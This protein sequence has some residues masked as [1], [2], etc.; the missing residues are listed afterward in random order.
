VNVD[1]AGNVTRAGDGAALYFNSSTGDLTENNTAGSNLAAISDIAAFMDAGTAAAGDMTIRDGSVNYVS[2]TT[3]NEIDVQNDTLTM[4]ELEA[5]MEARGDANLV[6]YDVDVDGGTG[7]GATYSFI[8]AGLSDGGSTL[9]V[10]GFDAEKI[11]TTATATVYQGDDGSFTDGAA[12]L[13]YATENGTLTFDEVSGATA[14]EDPLA[15]LDAALANV[16]SLRSELGAVQNRFMD[17]IT[18]LSTNTT[19]L[20]AA[21]SRIEDADY[22]VEVANMTRAQ[23]LQQAGTSVLAQANQ[24][25]QNVLSL[26]G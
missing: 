25:P 26:L 17:A 21:R 22:A 8:A 1:S 7:S 16:D 11:A 6:G 9:F 5:R 13:V 20:S 23:I 15:T 10:S 19:N 12:N 4:A 3:A 18:N 24:L 14:T 2:T